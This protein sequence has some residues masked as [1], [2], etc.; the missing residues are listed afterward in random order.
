MIED[1]ATTPTPDPTP[2]PEPTPAPQPDAPQPAPE[3]AP[4]APE[5]KERKARAPR[6]DRIEQNGIVRPSNGTIT[7]GVWD[8][9]DA[10]SRELGRPPYRS[11]IAAWG[12]AENL[13][14]SMVSSNYSNWR[15]FYGL[16]GDKAPGRAPKPVVEPASAPADATAAVPA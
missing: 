6:A 12:E 8:K 7:G 9:C 11:E 2:F 13:N 14:K 4:E 5:A 15:K 3:P 1:P 10:L 16:V